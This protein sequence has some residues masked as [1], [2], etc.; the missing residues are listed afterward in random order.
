MAARFLDDHPQAGGKDFVFGHLARLMPIV[1]D[2]HAVGPDNSLQLSQETGRLLDAKEH[3][4]RAHHVGH[5]IGQPTVVPLRQHRLDVVQV[6]PGNLVLFDI[7]S[8]GR[9]SACSRMFI[10]QPRSIYEK[11]AA[12]L[13]I[14]DTRSP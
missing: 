6:E 13:S 4:E 2:Q 9:L 3:V 12:G 11:D 7:L 10:L 1:N 14:P 8:V 5:V